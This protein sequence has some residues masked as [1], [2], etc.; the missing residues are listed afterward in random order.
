[1]L[2]CRDCGTSFAKPTTRGRPPVKCENCRS[3]ATS[4]VKT[5]KVTKKAVEA[6]QPVA[7]VLKEAAAEE[8]AAARRRRA[9]YRTGFCGVTR[10]NGFQIPHPPE[11]HK[12]CKGTAADSTCSCKCHEGVD[13][14]AT[15]NELRRTGR[16]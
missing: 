5:P 7:E 10:V 11:I 8:S 15:T 14:W 2:V 1:M 16:I 3:G 4:K 9:A 12:M 6:P 13:I